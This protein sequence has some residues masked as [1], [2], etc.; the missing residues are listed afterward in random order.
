MNA[1]PLAN[2]LD[3]VVQP[4][5]SSALIAPDNFTAMQG[6]ACLLPSTLTTFFGFEC[7]LGA[8]T[9][10]SDFLLFTAGTGQLEAA[11]QTVVRG[12]ARLLAK[13]WHDAA[14]KQALLQDPK[15][16]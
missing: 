5:V 15:E 10:P 1:T 14:Y 7:R 9:A 16:V 13:A 8:T 2:V 11:P 4:Y 12:Q 6:L 3:V